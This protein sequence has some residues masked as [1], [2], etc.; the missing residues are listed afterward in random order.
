VPEVWIYAKD[1]LKI[2]LYSDQGYTDS[3]RSQI[4]PDLPIITLVPQSIAQ[5][6]HIGMRQMLAELKAQLQ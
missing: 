4:F 1:H 6:Y 3:P 5:A 2:Y